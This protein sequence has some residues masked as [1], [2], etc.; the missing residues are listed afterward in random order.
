VAGLHSPEDELRSA[1]DLGQLRVVYQ[2]RYGLGGNGRL[3][4]FEALVR[5]DHPSRGMLPAAE[6][7]PLAEELGLSDTIGTFVLGQALELLTRTRR[8][9]DGLMVSINLSE[10]QLTNGGLA[11]ALSAVEAA[12]V[13]PASICADI[14]ER[15][16][17]HDP[18]L[19]RRAA[20]VLHAA[21]IRVAVDDYGTGDVSL[22]HLRRMHADE[23]KIHES[24]VR[25]L[26]D[27]AQAGVVRAVVEL[28]HALGM[29]VVAEGVETEGQ[30]EELRSLGCDFAHGFLLCRPVAAEQLE[31]MLARV[32]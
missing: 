10:K 7:M 28:G 13:Q 19:A 21:G 6:F 30:L 25:E 23:L 22:S 24:F 31:E 27:G 18:E 11:A 17:S 16:V 26:G 5:W 8:V 1:L 3:T 14:P 29:A 2:P 12:G 15:A 9:R 4:G 32:G 20:R